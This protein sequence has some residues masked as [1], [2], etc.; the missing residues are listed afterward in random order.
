MLDLGFWILG[1]ALGRLCFLKAVA[2]ALFRRV[3]E[4]IK[5]RLGSLHPLEGGLFT[6]HRITRVIVL[7]KRS[8]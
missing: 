6:V 7:L 5:D 1:R 8:G 3:R 2:L 4:I